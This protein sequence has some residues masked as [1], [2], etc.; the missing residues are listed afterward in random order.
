MGMTSLPDEIY[1]DAEVVAHTKAALD[2]HGSGPFLPQP[3][4]A[5]LLAALANKS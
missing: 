4:R 5:Q 3:T 1:T 2:Q